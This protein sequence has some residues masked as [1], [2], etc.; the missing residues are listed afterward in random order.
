MH[1]DPSEPEQ[2]LPAIVWDKSIEVG[3]AI[4]DAQH[5]HIVDLMN[6]LHNAAA[7]E[8]LD[9]ADVVL[10]HVVRFLQHHFETEEAVMNQIGYPEAEEHAAEHRRLLAQIADGAR[11]VEAEGQ[12]DANRLGVTVWSWMHEHTSTW[13]QRYAEMLRVRP[14]QSKGTV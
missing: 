7:G 9:T 8:G 6:A 11:S 14:V 13:D 2:R 4:L 3:D 1:M 12:P 10:H 5:R